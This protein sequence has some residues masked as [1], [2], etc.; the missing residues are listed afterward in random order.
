M[1]SSTIDKML[2]ITLFTKIG[3]KFT[4]FTKIGTKFLKKNVNLVPI[5]V[6]SVNLV[7]M[8]MVDELTIRSRFW[9]S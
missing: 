9:P 6:K 3:T 4:F 1:S 5:F 2:E 8:S 7:K